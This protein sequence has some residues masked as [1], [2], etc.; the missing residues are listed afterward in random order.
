MVVGHGQIRNVGLDPDAA[1][2]PA[3]RVPADRRTDVSGS[4][5][6]YHFLPGSIQYRL[7]D[8]FDRKRGSGKNHDR[9]RTGVCSSR[10]MA[11]FCG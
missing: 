5:Y 11:A 3:N 4:P 8:G 7:P 2:L 6:I 1:R 9:A 10:L